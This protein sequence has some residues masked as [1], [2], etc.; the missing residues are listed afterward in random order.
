MEVGDTIGNT[1]YHVNAFY[2]LQI[3]DAG[4][5]H[6]QA[7]W[8]RA[9]NEFCLI[10]NGELAHEFREG[11]P[12]GPGVGVHWNW[13]YGMAMNEAGQVVYSFGV[14]GN[15][16]GQLDDEVLY[17]GFDNLLAVEGDFV[18]APGVSAGSAWRDWDEVLFNDTGT[19]L[20]DAD[21]YDP[22][23]D[24]N[25]RTLVKIGIAPD[26]TPTG[27]EE[28]I[29]RELD[30]LNGTTI[31]EMPGTSRQVD[32]NDAGD[33]IA[34]L[35]TDPGG[36][37]E[38][39]IWFNGVEI[40]RDGEPSSVGGGLNWSTLRNSM[41]A[42]NNF[43]DYVFTCK[44]NSTTIRD[45]L[46]VNGQPLVQYG[47]ALPD[48]APYLLNYLHGK[49]VDIADTGDVLWYGDF[50]DPNP[51]TD[52]ALFLNDRVLVREGVTT[53]G[54][55]IIEEIETDE[56]SYFISDNGRWVVFEA[57]LV[58]GTEG[59][60]RIDLNPD[61]I[62]LPVVPGVAGMVNDMRVLNARPGGKVLIG[63]SGR[64]G[65]ATVMCNGAPL[66]SGL[67]N[68]V[69]KVAAGVVGL[70]GKVTISR[71]VA[72]SLIGTTWYLQAMDLGGCRLSN[73]LPVTF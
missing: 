48:I 59:L 42:V 68:P 9:T 6:A 60:Y 12:D 72:S 58:D 52:A 17:Y 20:A 73:V 47:D 14:Y 25:L 8:D 63:A 65:S 21:Y 43:G 27:S 23:L 4:D 26:G 16:N 66:I 49:E 29:V 54:G 53:I 56:F 38:S 31:L 46:I 50:N 51:D 61:P 57:T 69:Q 15:P 5:W 36:P 37:R 1:L 45:A 55:V 11:L 7:Y 33:V 41:V 40:A 39:I 30:T 13:T 64:R 32:M 19:M 34:N 67:G 71:Y 18:L 3:N 44:L 35:R 28:I 70:D 10:R 62:L 2:K 22:I 24:R